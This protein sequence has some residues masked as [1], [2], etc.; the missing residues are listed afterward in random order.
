MSFYKKMNPTVL[1]ILKNYT[2][3]L[4]SLNGHAKYR[5]NLYK[6]IVFHIQFMPLNLDSHF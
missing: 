6:C 3:G 1:I 2:C 4:F 5:S